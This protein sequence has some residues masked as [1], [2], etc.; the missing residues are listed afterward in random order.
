MSFE[1]FTFDGLRK[2]AKGSKKVCGCRMEQTARGVPMVICP[3]V[4][5]FADRKTAVKLFERE[6][7]QGTF[8]VYVKK[9]K[10]CKAGK[11]RV[12]GRCVPR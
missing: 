8:C 6:Q 3:G 4:R 1:M 11:R 9:G 7:A 10:R 5:R 2:P 12:G